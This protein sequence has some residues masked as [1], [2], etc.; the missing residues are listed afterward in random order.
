MKA[1]ERLVKR[2][3]EVAL[4]DLKPEVGKSSPKVITHGKRHLTDVPW[5][6]P[7]DPRGIQFFTAK[8]KGSVGPD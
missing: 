3:A 7:D 5:M 1:L 8:E 2:F 6:G 4:R